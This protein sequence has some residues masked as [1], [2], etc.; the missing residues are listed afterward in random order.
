MKTILKTVLAIGL[1]A[2]SSFAL[3][4][5][6]F[7]YRQLLQGVDAN[8]TFGM[9]QSE[10][11]EYQTQKMCL[12]EFG[13]IQEER[14]KTS[15]KTETVTVNEPSRYNSTHYWTKNYS[16]AKSNARYGSYSCGGAGYTASSCT[17]GGVTIRKG[18][19]QGSYRYSVS[20]SYQDRVSVP[21]EET[22]METVR[23]KSD[24]YDWCVNNGYETAN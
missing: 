12:K 8:P 1:V 17:S 21:Y 16:T 9:T 18:A 22:Y 11:D 4:E 24:K 10:K 23:E 15:Y 19:Y 14:T 20:I 6:K 7:S 2:S 5:G 13:E 3:A